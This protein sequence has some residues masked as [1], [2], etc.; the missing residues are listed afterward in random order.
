[1]GEHVIVN[2]V[3]KLSGQSDVITETAYNVDNNEVVVS[4]D[5]YDYRFV[6]LSGG[7]LREEVLQQYFVLDETMYIFKYVYTGRNFLVRRIKDN[8]NKTVSNMLEVLLY[9]VSKYDDAW[10]TEYRRRARR[11]KDLKKQNR[12]LWIGF[13]LSTMACLCALVA[14]KAMASS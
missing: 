11:I 5:V 9:L 10:E 13:T 14:L 6:F 2:R 3:V 4:K 7:R 8:S 12:N 1:M